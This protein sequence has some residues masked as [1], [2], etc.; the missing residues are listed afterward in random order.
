MHDTAAEVD[1]V[2]VHDREPETASLDGRIAKSTE[3]LIEIEP[4]W[5]DPGAVPLGEPLTNELGLE[6]GIETSLGGVLYLINVMVALDLPE[7]F[8]ADW[9]LASRLGHWGTLEALGRALLSS[10]TEED[11]ADPIW[12]ALAALAGREPSARLGGGLPRRAPYHPP[13]D[14]PKPP[15]PTARSRALPRSPLLGCIAPALGRWLACAL[16]AI[17]YRLETALASDADETDERGPITARLH[18]RGRLHVTLTHVDLVM[19]LDAISMAVRL[20]GLDRD[21]GWLP[22]FGRVV[23]FHFD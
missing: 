23:L 8:E 11:C 15:S 19:P 4:P 21:P 18:K 17:Q 3:T 20:A 12:A 2:P 10:P 16:P 6:D 14:W 22:T 1:D 9:Q 5:D 7:C 13:S